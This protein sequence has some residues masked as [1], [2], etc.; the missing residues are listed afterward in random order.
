MPKSNRLVTRCRRS[1][2]CAAGHQ[3][4][5]ANEQPAK[6]KNLRRLSHSTLVSSGAR[7]A[8]R[9]Q[10]HQRLDVQHRMTM[11]ADTGTKI[12]DT[13]SS[14]PAIVDGFAR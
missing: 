1:L 4:P 9:H 8:H 14:Q 2:G 7:A 3:G 13:M 5:T 10:R 6:R 12:P 11:K